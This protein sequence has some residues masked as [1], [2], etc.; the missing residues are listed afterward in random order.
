MSVEVAQGFVQ[1][2]DGGVTGEEPSQR[3]PLPLSSGKFGGFAFQKIAQFQ[4]L[5]NRFDQAP[6]IR[7]RVSASLQPKGHIVKN[8]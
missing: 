2:V 8:R 5:G 3:H 1:Q 4:P 7:S 6:G